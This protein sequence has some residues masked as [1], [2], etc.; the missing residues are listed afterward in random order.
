[1]WSWTFPHVSNCISY[2]NLQRDA[3]VIDVGCGT[4]SL[5]V[6]LAQKAKEKQIPI[7]IH[8]VDI[9]PAM[10]ARTKELA[11]KLNLDSIACDVMD[12]AHL[13]VP[14]NSFDVVTCMFIWD[15][16]PNPLKPTVLSEFHRIL[17]PGGLLVMSSWKKLCLV[18]MLPMISRKVG[19]E[20]IGV[21]K[22]IQEM[23]Y[24]MANEQ[25]IHNL[26]KSAGLHVTEIRENSATPPLKKGDLNAIQVLQEHPVVGPLFAGK[27]TEEVAQIFSEIFDE[28]PHLLEPVSNI[29]ATAYV[30]KPSDGSKLSNV[31]Q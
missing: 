14:D 5:C 25:M 3:R 31:S 29:S 6:P 17:K 23:V 1:M 19:I 24:S 10:I 4:G 12:A 18:E 15:A 13:N 26:C 28:N 27:S 9:S 7:S 21:L 20:T 8:A 22:E 30:V 11:K 2:I 16:I